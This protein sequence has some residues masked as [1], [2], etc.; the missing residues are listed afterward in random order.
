MQSSWGIMQ[1]KGYTASLYK[2]KKGWYTASL[3]KDQKGF[4]LPTLK[5]PR[6]NKEIPNNIH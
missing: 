6:F 1:K 4:V 2:D 5:P 3:Y